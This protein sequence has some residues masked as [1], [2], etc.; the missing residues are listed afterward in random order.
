M[1]TVNEKMT[2][3]ADAIRSKTGGTDILTLDG[4][5][6][7]I[8]GI[9]TGTELPELTN[10][11]TSSD[12]IYGKEF[13]NADGDKVVGTMPN[14]GAVSATLSLWKQSY[15]VP[16]G[17]HN[18]KGEVSL[19]TTGAEIVPTKEYQYIYPDEEYGWLFDEVIVEPIPDE[20]ITTTDATAAAADIRS[21]KTAYV[22]GSKVAGTMPTATQATPSVTVS[23]SG[24]ITASATQSAGYVASGTKKGTKQLTTQAAKTI[25]PSKSSQTA[26]ASGRYTT[27]A[28]TVAA[29]PSQYITTT[30]ATAA[31]ADIRSG[32][33]A[34]INGSKVTGTIQDFDGSYECSGD[35]TGGG[36]SGGNT[37]TDF[38]NITVLSDYST[39]SS[40]FYNGESGWVI[41][42]AYDSLVPSQARAVKVACGSIMS[43]YQDGYYA[44]TVSD[45]TIIR[46]SGTGCIY[47]VP[48]TPNISITITIET[49]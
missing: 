41:G 39:Y 14:N 3:I 13:V 37:S 7:A 10:P 47:Q 38:C 25:T 18:G 28:V 15:T 19:T 23:S 12:L 36:S 44:A 5:A 27:G 9:S 26:V 48:N 34:Y 17:Y 40:V 8:N 21:G 45:G 29:I 32:K 42:N 24:L 46:S 30:D 4:M 49:E 22:N 31:A 16:E 11:G 43:I 1:A 2:A 35:S 6:E 20:Y 33:T